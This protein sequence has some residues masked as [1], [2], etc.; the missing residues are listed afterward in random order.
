MEPVQE[1]I[2]I[3]IGSSLTRAGLA[4]NDAPKLQMPTVVGR[5]FIGSAITL[6]QKDLYIGREA[7]NKKDILQL[8]YPVRNSQVKSWPE[9]EKIYQHVFFNELN[10]D[11]AMHKLMVCE[12]PLNPKPAR[13]KVTE[14]MFE[15]LNVFEL[16]LANTSVM[17]LFATGRTTGIVVESGLSETQVVP[18]YEGFA[19]PHATLKLSVGGEQVT[20]FLIE[21]LKQRKNELPPTK[22]F[23]V[24]QQMKEKIC[25]CA[26][27]YQQEINTSAELL[28]IAK[29][30]E[31]P[32]GNIIT[33]TVE[34][35]RSPEVLFQPALL[36]KDE[37]GVHDLCY[38]S[39]MKCDADIRRELYGNMVLSGGNTMFPHMKN[40]FDRDMKALAPSNIE[41]KVKAPPE[42]KHLAWLGGAILASLSRFEMW[43]TKAEFDE[44]GTSIVHKKCF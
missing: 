1:A 31:L 28:T 4:A 22:E 32:D 44:V 18:I 39:I 27:D 43:I 20:N 25:Y 10:I 29:E 11:P 12:P 36:N 2:V 6:D 17:S 5:S 41:I 15:S 38:N 30:Y 23:E 14:F 42:R 19:L 26:T 24:A 3:D 40:R 13:E 8:A 37:P 34:R 16:Y 9:V 7:I 35:F 21:N 33:V